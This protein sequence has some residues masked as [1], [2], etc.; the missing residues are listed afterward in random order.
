MIWLLQ[1][2]YVSV[3]GQFAPHTWGTNLDQGDSSAAGVVNLHK[4]SMVRGAETL[5]VLI[6]HSIAPSPAHPPEGG[7]WNTALGF[8]LTLHC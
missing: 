7:A 6:H 1:P 3:L 5:P 4:Q 8:S 2:A